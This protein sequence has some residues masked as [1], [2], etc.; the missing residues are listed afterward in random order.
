MGPKL[1]K[2]EFFCLENE[3]LGFKKII[4]ATTSSQVTLNRHRDTWQ[5]SK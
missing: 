1:D 5:S 4:G 2:Q 3:K